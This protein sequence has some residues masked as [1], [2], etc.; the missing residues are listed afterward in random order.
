MG[1][2]DKTKAEAPV[3]ET[4]AKGKKSKPA[5]EPPAKAKKDKGA[6]A[7]KSSGGGSHGISAPGAGGM[8]QAVDHVEHLLLITPKGVEEDIVTSNGTANATRADVVDLDAKPIKAIPQA[9]IFQKVLQG[10]LIEA[11]ENRSRVLG[12][13]FIDEDAKKKGQNAPYKLRAPSK[14]DLARAEKYLDS[15]DPLR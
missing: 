9:L 5:P 1:K 6:K 3:E 7:G 4:K 15:L 13:L 8:F 10:Q 12:T 2:K 14:A 11:T